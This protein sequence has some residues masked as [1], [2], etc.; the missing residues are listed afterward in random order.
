M[1]KGY[2]CFI[3][4]V[5]VCFFG[6]N[7]SVAQVLE[8]GPSDPD[9]FNN[10]INIPDA[11]DIGDDEM[12]FSQIV[13]GAPIDLSQINLGTGGSVGDDFFAGAGTEVN[14]DGGNVGSRFETSG[15][16]FS[17]SEVNISQGS[18]GSNF[19]ASNNSLVNISGGTV[20]ENSNAGFN[21]VVNVS[22][23][24]VGA[25]FAALGFSQVN[26]SDG[27]IGDGLFIA[28]SG[29]QVNVSG[30][31]VGNGAIV[32]VGSNLN[33]SG[34][35]VGNDLTLSGGNLSVSGGSVGDGL[36]VSFATSL[37]V[38]GGSIGDNVELAGLFNLSGGEVGNFFSAQRGSEVNIFGTEFR[39]NGVL[40]D[41]LEG[42]DQLISFRD[43]TLSG[44]LA[45]GTDFSF[46]V[47]S[48]SSS[49]TDFF[50]SD[51]TINI[52]RVASTVPEPGSAL[53]IAVSLS[54]GFLRRSRSAL[55]VG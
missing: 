9:L 6:C 19:T 53:L 7:F 34:G 18:I 48:L 36:S 1:K 43:F 11:P 5:V 37:D 39:N 52:F 21:S 41:L 22:G 26:V 51:A 42:E 25:G 14:I 32:N 13:I 10:V 23:G 30:G 33:V 12:I 54:V 55:V 50:D 20:G 38:T 31:S 16:S 8:S 44:V 28:S 24:S 49:P 3:F 29:A 15:S 46:D 4:C 17:V 45:D 35:S 40:I 27:T 2:F 47:N